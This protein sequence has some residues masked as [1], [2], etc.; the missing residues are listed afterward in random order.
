M[1]ERNIKAPTLAKIL[2]T[3]RSNITRYLSGK[4]L[5][6]YNGFISIIEYFNISADVIL[7]L[8]EYT[9]HNTF[10]PVKPFN[11]RLKQVMAETCT[12]QYGI[13]KHTNIS[14][15]SIYNWLYAQRLPTVDSLIA[16]SQHM[17]ISI[18]YLL[19]RVN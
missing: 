4:R 6:L 13:E 10:L 5:P 17:G 3:D 19:G 8:K 18:D 15:S 16:L 11:E 9:E 2:R 14:S 1:I 12:T 7:G